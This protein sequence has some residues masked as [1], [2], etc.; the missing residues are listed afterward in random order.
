MQTLAYPRSPDALPQPGFLSQMMP[1]RACLQT[2]AVASP[3]LLRRQ[4]RPH[5]TP[6]RA[7]CAAAVSWPRWVLVSRREGALPG[8]AK[9]EREGAEPPPKSSVFPAGRPEECSGPGSP[10]GCGLTPTGWSTGWSMFPKGRRCG[11]FPGQRGGPQ[12]RLLASPVE[13]RRAPLPMGI[14]GHPRAGQ[15]PALFVGPQ[16]PGN[17]GA[18]QLDE[19]PR[20]HLLGLLGCVLE[21]VLGVRQHIEEGLDEF[22]VF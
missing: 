1:P 18:Q 4:A 20:E 15:L 5:V 10:P 21:V 9:G 11:D 12:S 14:P 22:L 6:K 8:Q 16:E 19:G 3:S 13:G 7:G 17:F 2:E